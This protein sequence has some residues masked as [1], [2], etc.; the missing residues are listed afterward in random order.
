MR[1]VAG[2]EPSALE[3]LRAIDELIGELE[4]RSRDSIDEERLAGLRAR[5]EHLWVEVKVN[6]SVPERDA[7]RQ[8]LWA[9]LPMAEAQAFEAPREGP[10]P[11]PPAPSHAPVIVAGVLPGDE[12]SRVVAAVEEILRGKPAR[13]VRLLRELA[14]TPALSARSLRLIAAVFSLVGSEADAQALRARVFGTERV[15]PPRPEPVFET[16]PTPF[17]PSIDDGL[18]VDQ[19][20]VAKALAV[21]GGAYVTMESV[22]E[23]AVLMGLSVDRADAAM[24]EL[25]LPRR[26]ALVDIWSDGPTRV[27]LSALAREMTTTGPEGEVRIHGGFF[28]NVIV[29][30]CATPLAFPTHRLAD[31]FAAAERLMANPGATAEQLIEAIRGPDLPEQSSIARLPT[32]LYRTGIGS[33][34]LDAC[35]QREVDPG[36]RSMTL[37]WVDPASAEVAADAIESWK[38]DGL[39]DGV[40]GVTREGRVVRIELDHAAFAWAIHRLLRRT[41][42][43]TR[44][45]IA[46]FRVERGTGPETVWLGALLFRFIENSRNEIRRSQGDPSMTR[47]GRVELLRAFLRALDEQDVARVLDSCLDTREAVWALTH[48]GSD[49][50]RQHPTFG[51]LRVTAAPFDRRHAEQIVFTPRLAQRRQL[52]LSELDALT[53]QPATTSSGAVDAMVK[54]A[55]ARVLRLAGDDPRR[56]VLPD[57]A[58]VV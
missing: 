53:L 7:P 51:S 26:Y 52:Y 14:K 45:S 25:L 54:E 8:G 6:R 34:E 46:Q 41:G 22:L 44:R 13:P 20:V 55:F 37:N 10:R 15:P 38:E 42:L 16:V 1:A 33:L 28:P 5:R 49:E 2:T 39:L 17:V 19:R 56:T 32:T 24:A 48:L 35:Q 11:E 12:D 31:V 50:F 36:G 21:R 3:A 43:I 9:P 4:A 29:N 47:G 58:R 18:T 23:D 27:R 57:R 30:G 40:G